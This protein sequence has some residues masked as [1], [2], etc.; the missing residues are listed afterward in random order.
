MLRHHA[1]RI[2]THYEYPFGGMATR[3]EW[4]PAGEADWRRDLAMIKDTGFDSI[5]IRIGLD[6]SLDEVARL[7]EICQRLGLGVLFGF[8]TFYVNDHFLEQFPDAKVIDRQGRAYP[9][10]RHDFRWQRGCIDHPEYRRRRDGLLADCAARFGAH[11]AVIAWDVHNEP[12]MGPGDCPCY[13]QHTVAKYRLDLA[14]R[15]RSIAELNRWW[16]TAYGGFDDVEPARQIDPAPAGPWREWREFTARNLCAFLREGADIIRQGVPGARTSFNVTSPFNIQGSGQ[17]WWIIPSLE[18]ASTSHYHGSGPQTAATAGAHIA[19]LKGLAPGKQV[20]L[21]EFQGGPFR[22]EILWRGINIEAEINQVFSHG[23]H[24][25]YFYRWEPLM[26]GA[27]P[28]INGMVDA[29]TYDTERRLATRRIIAALRQ[30]EDLIAA[31]LTVR[32]RIGIYLTREMVWAANAREAPLRET[33]YGLYGLF[34]DLGFEVGFLTEPFA[35]ECDLDVVL[36]PFALA[37]SEVEHEALG[38]YVARGGRVI[39]ELP[40]T[41]LEDCRAVGRRL[42]L[43]CREWIRPTYFL[44]SGWS[45]N[46]AAGRFGGFAF[47]DRVLVEDSADR[48]IA[49]YRDTGAS[50]LLAMGPE[51]RLL[52]PTFA[53]GRSYFSSLHRGLRRL[54]QGWLPAELTPDIAIG[55]M[56]EEYRSLVEARILESDAGGLLFVINRSGYEW[57]VEV[58]PRGYRAV[59]LKLP[60]YGAE[61]R[62]VT[63][64]APCSALVPAR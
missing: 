17:D 28:W 10:H 52:A 33:V 59:T 24:A 15:Y 7:L 64:T 14:A 12:S 36:V 29:D 50:A 43:T 42:G 2:G 45:L 23:C 18:Y 13:C 63:R 6:S 11:P 22:H 30:D 3:P 39:A 40:M 1:L 8:A 57:T 55:G 48:P 56:P 21:A 35:G 25:L 54:V 41:S 37:L 31:G 27:E 61:R 32:P 9:Q 38:A 62:P 5:R 26:A 34:L 60:S 53:L 58:T 46:D 44:V 20:W 49:R 4:L 16:G 47:H 19:L 51:G